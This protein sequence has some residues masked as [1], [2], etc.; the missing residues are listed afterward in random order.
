MPL[1]SLERI[2]SYYGD[3]RALAD[4]SLEVGDGEIVAVIG[5]NGAGKTTMLR[6]ISGLIRPRAGRICFQGAAIERMQA[7]SSHPPRHRPCTGGAAAVCP[8]DRTR[9]PADGRLWRAE[10]EGARGADR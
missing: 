2:S 6:T 10:L 3:A 1:L 4:V 7:P 5:S 9:E 8:D